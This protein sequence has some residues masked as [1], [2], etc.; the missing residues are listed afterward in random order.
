MQ[1]VFKFTEFIVDIL[2]SVLYNINEFY[3]TMATA[4]PI[5]CIVQAVLGDLLKINGVVEGENGVCW[6]YFFA[7]YSALRACRGSDFLSPKRTSPDTS[8]TC[9]ACIRGAVIF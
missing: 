5:G 9:C 6:T 8:T 1:C 3:L 4:L 2:S 7:V